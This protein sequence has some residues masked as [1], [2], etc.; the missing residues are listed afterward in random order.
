MELSLTQF[1]TVDGV[2][3]APG[4]PQEDTSGGFT[5]GGW[6]VPFGDTEFGAFIDEVFERADAFLLGRRTYEI[7]AGYWPKVTDPDNPVA[8]QLNALPKYVATATLE[9]ADWAGTEL[10]RG[11]VVAEVTALK[12]RPGRELQV[13]GSRNLAHTLL[14]NGLVDTLHLLTFPVLLGTGK[15]LF[16]SE[17]Q[18]TGLRLTD[19][20]VTGSGIVISTYRN[21]GAPQYG[22]YTEVATAAQ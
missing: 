15:R 17:V 2:C 5:H 9:H 8:V 11:D 4:G 18:P 22:D 19:Y 20:R 16:T 1:V 7:F 6:S 21:A 13:H 10:L 14:S 12:Q 3:Q